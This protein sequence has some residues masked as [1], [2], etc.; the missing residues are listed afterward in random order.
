[1]KKAYTGI[2]KRIILWLGKTLV[3]RIEDI[4][5]YDVLKCESSM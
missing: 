4:E 1:M 2:W 5:P 3:R